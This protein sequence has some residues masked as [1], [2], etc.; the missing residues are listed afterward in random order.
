MIFMTVNAIIY[1]TKWDEFLILSKIR[2]GQRITPTRFT[3]REWI[4][5]HCTALI[6]HDIKAAKIILHWERLSDEKPEN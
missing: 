5:E 1:R 2:A 6:C 3:R 4:G